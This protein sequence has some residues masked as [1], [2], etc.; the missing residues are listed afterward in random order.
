MPLPTLC[1]IVLAGIGAGLTALAAGSE[2][3]PTG[4]LQTGTAL[5][6][7]LGSGATDTLQLEMS[8]DKRWSAPFYWAGFVIQGDWK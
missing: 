2:E 7:D 8:R 4:V 1:A 5:T 6:R 3:S